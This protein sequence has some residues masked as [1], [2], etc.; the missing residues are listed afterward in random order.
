MYIYLSTSANS[1]TATADAGHN[2]YR[3]A[4]ASTYV[5]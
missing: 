3:Q 5:S 2:K 4:K 1:K